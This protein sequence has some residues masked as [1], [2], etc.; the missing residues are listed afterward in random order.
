MWVSLAQWVLSGISGGNKWVSGGQL[1]SARLSR[2]QQGQ[3]V[4]QR[5]SARGSAGLQVGP[6]VRPQEDLISVTSHNVTVVI[7]IVLSLS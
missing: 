2:V 4:G 6:Q 5:G 7:H 3:E 1:V